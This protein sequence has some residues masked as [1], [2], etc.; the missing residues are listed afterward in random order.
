M[1]KH[2]CVLCMKIYPNDP[3]CHFLD[4]FSGF[5]DMETFCWLVLSLSTHCSIDF[6]RSQIPLLVKEV[7]IDPESWGPSWYL[8]PGV[9]SIN[10]LDWELIYTPTNSVWR[11][12]PLLTSLPVFVVTCFLDDS[13]SDWGELES[14]CSLVCI[15][16]MDND[17]E[18]FF[19][20]LLNIC[21]SS[22]E[23]C[24]IH[25]SIYFWFFDIKYSEY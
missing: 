21:A 9:D 16:F 1:R 8:A 6:C 3:P 7:F 18:Y 24:S 19:M 13:Q 22:S 5:F 4:P 20:C 17:V 25:L 12:F 2:R 14:L 15:Y 11:F 23:T 10:S